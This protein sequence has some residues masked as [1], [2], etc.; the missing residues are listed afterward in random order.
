VTLADLADEAFVDFPPGFG[1]RT[2]I[3][4]R[5]EAAG[6][7]RHVVVEA[8]GIENGVQFVA[9]GV[10]LGVL[11]G[12]AVAGVDAIRVVP[13]KDESFQ[14]SL[15]MATLKKRKPTAALRALLGLVSTHLQQPPGTELGQD[16]HQ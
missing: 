16:L 10:G 12:Y 4:Q 9:H 6:L 1:T 7:A 11:P 14:W 13:I 8:L 15:Y 3:D 5:F 2:L